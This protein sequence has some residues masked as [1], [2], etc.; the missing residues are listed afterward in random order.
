MPEVILNVTGEGPKAFVPETVVTRATDPVMA[1]VGTP[2]DFAAQFPTPLDTTEILDLCEDLGV[3]NS[4]PEVKT[5]LKAYTWREMTSLD[6]TSGS[7]YIA[8]SDGTCPEE[9]AHDGS[10]QTVD[11][12][13]IG[14]KKSLEISDIMHSMASINAGY[15]INQL[16]GGYSAG[17][18][19][20][21]GADAASF[22][23]E[24]IA[25]LKAKEIRLAM[26]LV[27][28]G[29]DNLLVNG[30]THVTALEFN[31][32]VDQVTVSNGAHTST[33]G[34]SGSFSA[35]A[36]DRFMT[37]ACAK[38]TALFGHPAAIQELMAGYFALG[39]NGSQIITNPAP[40]NRLEPGYNFT[41]YVNT[42]VGR[43]AVVSDV[44]FPRVVS[45]SGAFQSTIY[46]LRMTHNGE[47]LVHKITQIPLALRDLVPGCTAI[48]FEVW[49]KT[50]LII[51]AM[52]AQ[53]AYLGYFTGRITSTCTV[54]G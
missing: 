15:G 30:D 6:F 9:Y 37:E 40:G 45:G 42:G 46:A 44:R 35:L 49:A 2:A 33:L 48:A 31:G 19:L 29:W 52:C 21:G 26:T 50:A 23:K 8:F 32:I 24:Q 39:F 4:I 17:Q 3:W 36:F 1:N 14:A 20:P 16:V 12:K 18:G 47:P 11:L 13:N 41:G 51:K 25:D 34:A 43:L 27:L 54:I 22:V 7:Q 10:N 5:G 28:N 53:S 38:P